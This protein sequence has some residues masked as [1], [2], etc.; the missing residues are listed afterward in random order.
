MS[1]LP[2]L[3]YKFNAVSQ[4]R[5]SA[6]YFVNVNKV[7]LKFIWKS[8]RQRTDSTILNTILKKNK[9]RGFMLIG[10]VQ[11]SRSVVSDS[12]QCHEPQHARHPGPSPTPRVYPNP[13]PLYL[14]CHPTISSSVVPFFSCPQSFPAS[15]LF[16]ISQLFA[17]GG[18][19][20]SFNISPSNEHPGL[21]SF[22][23]DWFDLMSI[24]RL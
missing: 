23:I 5:T 15:G 17:S 8:K 6:H 21:I 13:C 3:T 19:S 12:L 18:P 7:I 9:V 11:F 16:Q 14:W 20:F 2:N 10:S 4:I 1:V 22:R 24:N